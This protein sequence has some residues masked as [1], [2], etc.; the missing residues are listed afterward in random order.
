MTIRMRIDS[1]TLRRDRPAFAVVAL[2]RVATGRRELAAVGASEMGSFEIEVG[3][4]EL[5]GFIP[6]TYI[7]VTIT[8]TAKVQA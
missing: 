7:D 4:D 5:G 2:S 8:P 3:A 6:G 1:V